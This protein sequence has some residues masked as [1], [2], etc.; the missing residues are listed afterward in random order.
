AEAV[1][2][3]TPTPTGRPTASAGARPADLAGRLAALP[4][5][6]RH[7][8][9]VRLIREQAANVLGHHTDSLTTGGTFKELGF[10]SLTAVE[11]RNTL[12]A[13]TGLRLPSG[14]V[15]DYP[16]ADALAEHLGGQ[17][18]PEDGTPA[19]QEATDPLLRE[20]AQLENALSSAPVEHIDAD[21]VTAR[22]ESLLSK[23]KAVGASS[24]STTA[25]EQLQVATTDQVLDF[26]DKELGV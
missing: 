20:L 24:G 25:K 8:T 22:L 18:A 14:L 12:S 2:L 9:L 6:D 3:A 11:L 1:G 10:D 16:D 17:L 19:G 15:F 13:A 7:H 5:S 26:I 23:W 21:A 4:P